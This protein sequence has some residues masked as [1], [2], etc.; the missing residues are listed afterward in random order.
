MKVQELI[1][2]LRAFDGN[3]EVGVS[4]W[5]AAWKLKNVSLNDDE[6]PMV[7]MT[8]EAANFSNEPE[9]EEEST[10]PDPVYSFLDVT[11]KMDPNGNNIKCYPL[12]K[13]GEVIGWVRKM[14]MGQRLSQEAAQARNTKLRYWKATDNF[15]LIEAVKTILSDDCLWTASGLTNDDEAEDN[16]PCPLFYTED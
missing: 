6:T 13:H 4:Y 9:E 14:D 12:T 15:D 2:A 1:E 8:F 3:L 10:S 11:T 7:H 5:D 16:K